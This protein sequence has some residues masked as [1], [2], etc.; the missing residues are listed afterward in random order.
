MRL[1]RGFRKEAEE[2]ADE[3]RAELSLHPVAPLSGFRLAEHLEIPVVALS[4]LPGL[5]REILNYFCGDGQQLFSATTI[6]DDSNNMIVHNDTHHPYRQNSNI[7]HE[8]A[9]ILLGHPSRPPFTG[10]GC[11]NFDAVLEKE[12]NELGFAILIPKRAA[13]HIVE[14]RVP[15]DSVCV[16][17]GVSRKLLTYRIKITD[18]AGWAENR[19]R[20]S[21]PVHA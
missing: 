6:N 14:S 15:I 2:Y 5:P 9:H 11:R 12:A 19:R 10:D 21:A 20:K 1:R 18:A 3:F 8:I 4:R 13:L 7:M 17:Y 16:E